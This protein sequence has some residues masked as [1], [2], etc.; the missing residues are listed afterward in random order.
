MDAR[1][2]CKAQTKML[3]VT[4]GG[5]SGSGHVQDLSHLPTQTLRKDLSSGHHP[6]LLRATLTRAFGK[7]NAIVS[8]S[9]N[10]FWS[11]F[12]GALGTLCPPTDGV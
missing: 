2:N 12:Q 3:P 1:M 9:D 7:D 11:W 8:V 10:I 6:S 4:T 5:L